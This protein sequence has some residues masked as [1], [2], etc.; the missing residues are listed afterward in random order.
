MGLLLLLKALWRSRGFSARLKAFDQID[1][2]VQFCMWKE[3]V[4]QYAQRGRPEIADTLAVQV[5]KYLM[6]HDLDAVRQS[7]APKR[8]GV[9]DACRHEVEGEADNL[10]RSDR[11]VNELVRRSL[12]TK[13]IL[14]SCRY[15]SKWLDSADCTNT[16]ERIRRYDDGL[17]DVHRHHDMDEY[18]R[19]A[20]E[21]LERAGRWAEDEFR[22]HP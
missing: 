5:T 9:H 6:G 16:Q 17:P 21:Y 20:H 8:R 14:Y 2:E 7:A 19:C 10:M 18:A 1:A 4:N 22:G 11:L 3:L 15:G 13:F 12:M